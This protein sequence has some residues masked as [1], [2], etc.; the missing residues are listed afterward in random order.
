M[1]SHAIWGLF[2]NILIQNWRKK[3]QSKFRGGVRQP[4]CAPYMDPPLVV[5]KAQNECYLKPMDSF[6]MWWKSNEITFL[7]WIIIYSSVWNCELLMPGQL[8]AKK[9]SNC[10]LHSAI[11]NVHR[12]ILFLG[13][14]TLQHACHSKQLPVGLMVL[15]DGMVH[16]LKIENIF[17]YTNLPKLS[18]GFKLWWTYFLKKQK[19]Y[20]L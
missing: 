19:Q 7:N 5:D 13:I 3:N 15:S 12:D 20:W 8:F 4:C 6:G 18:C 14:I 2:W 10:T 16:F 17:F 1:L 9:C 11:G